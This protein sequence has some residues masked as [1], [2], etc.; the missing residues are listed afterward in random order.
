MEQ[1]D[2][3][4][5]EIHRAIYGLGFFIASWAVLGATLEVAISQQLNLSALDS[6]HIT[7]GMQF[8]PKAVML[9]SLLSRDKAKNAKAIEI[10]NQMQQRGERNDLLHSIVGFNKKELVFTRRRNDRGR[11]TS[12]EK[13]YNGQQLVQLSHDVANLSA[14]LKAELRITDNDYEN[15]LQ[16]AHKDAN[17]AL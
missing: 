1:D 5:P 6:S 3:F 12:E 2:S 4:T 8:K 9:K 14:G 13:P 15:W 16:E 10:V 17:R 11:F 7:A